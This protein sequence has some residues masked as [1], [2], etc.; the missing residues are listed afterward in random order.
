MPR[1]VDK[2]PLS[3]IKF[4]SYHKNDIKNEQYTVL[5]QGKACRILLIPSV[6]LG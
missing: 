2:M 6:N 5:K 3:Q 1:K 4:D